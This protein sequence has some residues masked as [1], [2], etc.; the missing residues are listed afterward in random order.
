MTDVEAMAESILSKARQEADVITADARTQAQEMKEQAKRQA[1]ELAR[2]ELTDAIGALRTAAIEI[3]ARR[4]ELQADG[5][6]EAVRLAAAIAR[7]V[8]KRQ[9]IIDSEALVENLSGAMGLIIAA[10]DLRVA[11]HPSQR[12]TVVAALP[13]LNVRWPA[14]RHIEVID[15]P[16]IS[17][18]GCR[19]FTRG[20]LIDADLDSQL[21]RVI[22][23]IL[24]V[25]GEGKP[26]PSGQS[27]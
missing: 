25:L 18:G 2:Q 5:L 19:V 6:R 24:P 27:K 16:A 14:L 8:T 12:A 9:G 11:I 3:E 17:P 21:D 7:K 13:Q 23:E 1:L 10:A 26:A 20:G 22:A 15:D 4:H